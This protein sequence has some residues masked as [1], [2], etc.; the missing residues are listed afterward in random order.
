[1][2]N[3]FRH[4]RRTNFFNILRYYLDKFQKRSYIVELLELS[5]F[6]HR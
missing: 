5:E 1:M 2:N 6:V 4:S 3:K